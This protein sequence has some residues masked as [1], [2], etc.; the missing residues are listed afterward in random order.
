MKTNFFELEEINLNDQRHFEGYYKSLQGFYSM[1]SPEMLEKSDLSAFCKR[2]LWLLE[3]L[4]NVHESEESEDLITILKSELNVKKVFEKMRHEGLSGMRGNRIYCINGNALDLFFVG[5]LHSD[6]KALKKIL[7]RMHFFMRLKQ[8]HPFKIIFLGDYVDRGKRH[9]ELVELLLTLK[10]LWPKQVVLLRGNHDGG[11]VMPTGEIELAYKL[12]SG[13]NLNDYF[14][15]YLEHLSE[16]NP[17]FSPKMITAYLSFF[18]TLGHCA[19]IHKQDRY[20]LAV[21]GGLPRPVYHDSENGVEWYKHLTTFSDFTDENRVDCLGNSIR[22][23]M[24][25]SDPAPPSMNGEVVDL[26]TDKRRFRF[27]EAQFVSFCAA[28]GIQEIIRGHQA[29][30]EGHR[31]HFGGVHTLFSS[32]HIEDGVEEEHP[33]ME[34]TTAYGA[35]Q[36][37]I[38]ALNEQGHWIEMSLK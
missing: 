33:I 10:L 36:P 5:D 27:S 35:I 13:S 7:N 34:Q 2:Q 4:E 15:L 17:T 3:K 6:P 20:F 30:V 19:L 31:I 14:P 9:L 26:K 25:W 23:N 8:N 38:L 1:T 32:G 18:N 12:D 24:M 11:K 37:K 21:H 22:H 16:V 28:T 29:V